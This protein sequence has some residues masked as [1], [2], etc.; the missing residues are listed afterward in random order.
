MSESDLPLSE[1]STSS[2]FTIRSSIP[3]DAPKQK[4]WDVLLDFTSYGEWRVSQELT[5]CSRSQ[6]IISGH[7]KTPLPPQTA[8]P[9]RRLRL[10]LHV[11]PTMDDARTKVSAAEEILT[12]V[13][14]TSFRLAW[15]FA[16]PAR[17]LLCAERWQILRD[18]GRLSG[19]RTVYE[20]WEYFG[21]LLAYVIWF[22]MRAKLQSSFDAMSRALKDRAER[23]N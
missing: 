22:F 18:D 6:E 21:G 14:G 5:I 16:T 10:Q 11:P 1:L 23:V 4:V 7:D 20:T 17:W 15:R 13:D 2:V 3:I 12:H 8:A 9:G 19:Q